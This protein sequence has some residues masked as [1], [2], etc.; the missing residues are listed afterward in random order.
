MNNIT[1]ISCSYNTP[2]VT[3]NMLK[4]FVSLHP[5]C[6]ILIS[7]NS[8]NSDTENILKAANIPYILNRG[9]THG[10]SVDKLFQQ[11]DTDYVL[12]VDTDVIFLKKHDTIF[13]NFQKLNL[14]I[15]GEVVGDRG[16]KKLYK[17]VNPWH[18]FI[19]LQK[20]KEY[21]INFFDTERM[22]SRGK[23]IYDVGSTF[24]E[25]VRKNNLK[26][27]I[28]E[29]N[30]VY[31]KHYEGL[32]WRVNKFNKNLSEDGNIDLNSEAFH[33]NEHLMQYG[34]MVKQQ[35]DIE[36]KHLQQLKLSYE[37]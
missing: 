19:N 34:L 23:I 11:V 13:E 3:S 5:E 4:S 33:C 36:T 9:S 30:G 20:I 22:Q 1:L 27:G 7:E 21:K 17:R 15:M 16:G 12:L 29:G 25:D 10:P 18:C 2:D 31:Y 26:I 32:S 28:F 35:Y 6:P 24:F 8:T 14:T 37:C